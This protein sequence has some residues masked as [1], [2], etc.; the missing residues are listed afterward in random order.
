[1]AIST[2]PVGSLPQSAKLQAVVTDHGCGGSRQQRMREQDACRDSHPRREATGSPSALDEEHRASSF[3]TYPLKDPLA[4]ADIAA[5][6]AGDGQY[7][8]EQARAS[9]QFGF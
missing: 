4:E 2:N 6:L 1:M 7:F 3:A 5:D 8:L 9:T